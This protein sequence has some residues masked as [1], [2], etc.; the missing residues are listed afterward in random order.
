MNRTQILLIALVLIGLAACT[1]ASA[2]PSAEPA[3][4][5]TQQGCQPSPIESTTSGFPEIQ[6]TMKSSGEIWALLFFGKAQALSDA[7][8]VWRLS[9]SGRPDFRAENEN[10]TIIQPNWGPEH[11]EDSTWKRPGEEWGTSFNFPEPGCWTIMAIQGETSG[12][13]QLLVDVPTT[14]ENPVATQPALEDI[15]WATF[16][17]DAG[18]SFEHPSTWTMI[19]S[20]DDSVEFSGFASFPYLRVEVYHRPIEEKTIGDPHSWQ[21]NE[22][23]YEILWEKSI[24]IENAEGLEFI[25]GTPA[26]NQLGATLNAMYYSEQHELEVRLSTNTDST[27]TQ[28][29]AFKLFER[30]VQSVR[31]TP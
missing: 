26:D 18:V 6:A 4:I 29:D 10:G 1:P 28:S 30:I 9:G 24:S 2:L 11:H 12:Q 23:G 25:W 22:G 31:I 21:P 20:Q 14:S 8:I 15:K 16:A 27:S 13:I 17:F 3:P 19:S 7:K 5:D